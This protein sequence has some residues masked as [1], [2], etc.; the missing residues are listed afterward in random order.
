[1]ILHPNTRKVEKPK[2]QS[3]AKKRNPNKV[4]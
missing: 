2:V 4:P 3:L 1:M